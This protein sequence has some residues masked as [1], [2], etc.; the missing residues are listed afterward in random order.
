MGS[1]R[2]QPN[3]D[4]LIP[5]AS[6]VFSFANDGVTVTQNGVAQTGTTHALRLFV[7][8]AGEF[9]EPDST[10]TGIAIANPGGANANVNVA[11]TDLNGVGAGST[12]MTIPAGGQV[13]MFLHEIPSFSNLATPFEGILRITT[14]SPAG[15]SAIG[16]RGLYN[17][18]HDF[19]IATMPYIDE[20]GPSS[21][22]EKVF[23]HIVNGDGYT[24][25]FILMSR[26]ATTG[27]V[28]FISQ[29]GEPLP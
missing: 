20:E 26:T 16:L 2:I 7:E 29:S 22:S 9:G 11:L 21:G 1:I 19:L 6:T 10:R 25:Q 15:V 3:A 12:S 24:T 28:R 18:R 5:I 14:T 4:N 17:E 13:A 27:E 23:P 8:A